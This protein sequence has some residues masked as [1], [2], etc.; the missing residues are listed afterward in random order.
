MFALCDLKLK[1]YIIIT[2]MQKLNIKN[3][4]SFPQ[5]HEL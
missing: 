5:I 1:W 2:V 4:I 3:T